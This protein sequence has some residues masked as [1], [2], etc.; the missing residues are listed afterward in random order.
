MALFG[1]ESQLHLLAIHFFFISFRRPNRKIS[2][3]KKIKTRSLKI[4]TLIG[5]RERERLYGNANVVEEGVMIGGGR[6]MV[7]VEIRVLRR[8]RK[9]GT[10]GGGTTGRIRGEDIFVGEIKK[11]VDS[12]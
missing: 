1:R 6:E 5:E 12:K 11:V 10:S 7:V 3:I 4:E 9:R 8:E 2:E